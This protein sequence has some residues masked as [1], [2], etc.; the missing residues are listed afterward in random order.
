MPTQVQPT[1]GTANAAPLGEGGPS[2]DDARAAYDEA[3]RA[4]WEFQDADGDGRDDRSGMTRA[5]AQ[6]ALVTAQSNLSNAQSY[7]EAVEREPNAERGRDEAT[8]LTAEQDAEE[9]FRRDEERRYRESGDR[10]RDLDAGTPNAS[11]R[12][13]PAQQQAEQEAQYRRN[14]GQVEQDDS[15]EEGTGYRDQFTGANDGSGGAGGGGYPGGS[16]GGYGSGLYGDYQDPGSAFDR[17]SDEDKALYNVLVVGDGIRAR[18]AAEDAANE[19][20]RMR[21]AWESLQDWAPTADDLAVDYETGAPNESDASSL[22]AQR[23]ALRAMQDV[24]Q[25]G[26]MTAADRSRHMQARQM[27]GQQMRSTREADMAQLQSRGMGGSGAQLASM[28]GA[29]QQGATSLSMQDASMLQ[30]AQRRALQAMQGA[31]QAAGQVGNRVDAFN[32]WRHGQT[33]QTR[34][35]RSRARQDQFGNQERIR[36]GLT[37]QWRGAAQDANTAANGV[38]NASDKQGQ[39]IGSFVTGVANIARGS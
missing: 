2:I 23:D 1:S 6:Q 38:Q 33:T 29:Q 19:A 5:E 28:L 18:V 4:H 32:Q 24:Y 37:N 13:S 21:A 30:D 17:L 11:R 35:S 27:A 25:S 15:G 39:A 9:Q 26:G 8:Q 12:K 36:A 31:G 3:W 7:A 34:E 22:D 20:A 16:G 10:Q 14:L